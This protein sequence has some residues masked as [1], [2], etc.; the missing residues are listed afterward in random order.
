MTQ[1]S[2]PVHKVSDSDLAS[3]SSVIERC[4]RLGRLSD[5]SG[6]VD[7]ALGGPALEEAMSLVEGWMGDAGLTCRRDGFG[8]LVGTPPAPAQSPVLLLGSHLDT[9]PDGGLFDGALGV[10]LAIAAAERLPLDRLPFVLEVVAFADE[11]GRFG[12]GCLGSRAFVGELGPQDLSLARP[13]GRTLDQCLRSLGRDPA[14]AVGRSELPADLIGYCEVHV[15]Q[16]TVLEELDLPVGVVHRILGKTRA[17]AEVTGKAEHASSSKVEDRRDACCGIAE[18][19]LAVEDSMRQDSELR[20]TVGEVRL[21]PEAVNVVAGRAVASIDL[22]HPDDA[23]RRLHH[24]SLR[25]AAREIAARRGLDLSWQH[26]EEEQAVA[27]DNA[28]TEA[29]AE[30]SRRVGFNPPRMA[31]G[32]GHDA[33]VIGGSAPIAMLFVRCAGGVTHHPDEDVSAADA[34]VA[35]AVLCEFVEELGRGLQTGVGDG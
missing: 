2:V 33:A 27:C 4:G 13:D 3:A 10:V 30:A 19:V 29:L 15:E 34:E 17:V 25:S 23:S 1:Y 9:V 35:L 31:S 28:L 11:E 8:N 20:A 7:R 6:R 18:L 26:I 14:A 5:T 21:D 22:R 12:K 24:E 32:A 16:A